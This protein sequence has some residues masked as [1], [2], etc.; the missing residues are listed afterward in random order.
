MKR[1]I[2]IFAIALIVFF[3][4]SPVIASYNGE[5]SVYITSSGEK[6]HSYGCGSLWN[7][8]FKISLEDAVARGYSPCG[9]CYPPRLIGVPSS[10]PIPSQHDKISDDSGEEETLFDIVL[11]IIKLPFYIVVYGFGFIFVSCILPCFLISQGKDVVV[12][13]FNKRRE[14]KRR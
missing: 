10:T 9:R 6:Y 14:Q 11:E 1:I 5:T 7:S 8:S 13:F 12:K 3:V 2:S 4:F